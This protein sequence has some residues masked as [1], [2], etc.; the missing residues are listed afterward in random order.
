MQTSRAQSTFWLEAPP[1]VCTV[2]W[3]LQKHQMELEGPVA[4]SERGSWALSADT[5]ELVQSQT[6]KH[7]RVRR[8]RPGQRLGSPVIQ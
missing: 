4:W 6:A 2:M 1:V 8:G 7:Q 5:Q 3:V